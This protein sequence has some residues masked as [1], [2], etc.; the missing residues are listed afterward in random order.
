M[1]RTEELE[2]NNKYY[3]EEREKTIQRTK[4]KKAKRRRGRFLVFLLLLAL[5]CAG[6]YYFLKSDYFVIKDI[7]VS[8]NTY[9]TKQEVISIAKASTGGNIIFDAEVDSIR[10]NLEANPFF[11]EVTVKRKLPSTLSI[12]VIERPQIA[13]VE[14]GDSYI[15]IDDEGVILRRADVDPRITVI[16]GLT[17]S[18][19]DVGEPIEAEEKESLSTTLRLLKI[20][21][22]G[23]LFFKRVDVS[24]VVLKAYIYDNLIVKGT[25]SEMFSA[26][27]EGHVQSVVSDLFSKG[28]TRGTIKMG[29]KEAGGTNVVFTPDIEDGE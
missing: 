23:D 14:F 2:L 17:I 15:V 19:M 16:T 29:G 11:K 28:I 25:P 1:R 13:A 26:I 4:R 6:A 5:I 8:G 18:K 3:E 10:D 24:K 12:E 21:E 9:Y 7:E 22:E 27:E 20:M